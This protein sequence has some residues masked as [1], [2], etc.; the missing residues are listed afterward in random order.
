LIKNQGKIQIFLKKQDPPQMRR[1]ITLFFALKKGGR[2]LLFVNETRILMN[3]SADP[4]NNR[5]KQNFI[6][7]KT[8][9]ICA[10]CMPLSPAVRFAITLFYKGQ[11]N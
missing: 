7:P 5:L 3:H 11:T 8:R 10:S 4:L 6:L 9:Y 1:K 2:S